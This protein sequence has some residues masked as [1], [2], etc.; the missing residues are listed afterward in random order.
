MGTLLVVGGHPLVGG[1][2]DLGERAEE[3]RVEH[4]AAEGTVEALDEGVLHRPAGLDVVEAY[5]VAFAPG[6]KLRGD[7]LGV[8]V[9]PDLAG[10]RTAFLELLQN[11]DDPFGGQ[12]GIHFD[13]KGFADALVDDVERPK[14][15]AV[16]KRV[17]HE[18]H[19]PL[20]FRLRRGAERFPDAG[21][22]PP[23]GAPRKVEL[24]GFVNP[25]D[26]LVVRGLALETHPVDAFPEAPAPV[27]GD[28]LVEP[29]DDRGVPRGIVATRAVEPR[30]PSLRARQA[31]DTGI[32]R[33]PTS[34]PTASWRSAGLRALFRSAPSTRRSPSRDPHTCVSAWSARP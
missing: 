1:F 18:V 32:Q 25:P 34:Q 3:V 28:H 31:R 12:R 7:E 13:G 26:A 6:D 9:H 21:R 20:E 15:L 27:S 5:F 22:Q 17:M 23:L 10:Q 4:H 2:A 30:S 33:S 16:V 8:V 14:A 19:R 24:H 29:R 11:A